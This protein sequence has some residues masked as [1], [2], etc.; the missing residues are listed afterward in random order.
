VGSTSLTT[1][2]EF[3]DHLR[4]SFPSGTGFMLLP[5]LESLINLD[6]VK[7]IEDHLWFLWNSKALMHLIT[8]PFLFNI[9]ITFQNYLLDGALVTKELN[10]PK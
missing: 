4:P 3:G 8:G 7:G 5:L 6:T 9:I 10:Y 1:F 2:H